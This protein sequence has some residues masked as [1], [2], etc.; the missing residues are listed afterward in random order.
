[1]KGEPALVVQPV[2][3]WAGSYRHGLQF[4]QFAARRQLQA[5]AGGVEEVQ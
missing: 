5:F 3:L 4:L 2:R 1:M